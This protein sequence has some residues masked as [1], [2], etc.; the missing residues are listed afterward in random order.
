[1]NK[2]DLVDADARRSLALRHPGGVPVSAL[3]GEGLEALEATMARTIPRP[4]AELTLLI[5]YGRDEVTARL[6]REGEIL[7]SE[8]REG[9]TLMRARVDEPL[10]SAVREFETDGR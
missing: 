5:P 4:E 1:L 9:G 6:H 10:R 7:A 8:S 3:S 2:I